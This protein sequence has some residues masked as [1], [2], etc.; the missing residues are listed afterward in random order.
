MTILGLPVVP[1]EDIIWT[2]LREGV[3]VVSQEEYKENSN[4]PGKRVCSFL[5]RET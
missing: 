1:I 3:A 4:N 2:F 5:Q